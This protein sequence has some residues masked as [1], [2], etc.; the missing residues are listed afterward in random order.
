MMTY[1]ERQVFGYSTVCEGGYPFESLNND[2]SIA[3]EHP[4][5]TWHTARHPT[6]VQ[7]VTHGLSK[8]ASPI[9]E[10]YRRQACTGATDAFEI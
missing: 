9:R 5:F 2:P 7:F 10:A 8:R 1:T 4:Q 6:A 3:M